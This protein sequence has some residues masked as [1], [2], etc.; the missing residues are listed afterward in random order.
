[1]WSQN[2]ELYRDLILPFSEVNLDKNLKQLNWTSRAMIKKADDFYI[3]L[4]LPKMAKTFWEKSYFKRDK[5]FRNCHGTAAN[6][7]NGS[8]YRFGWHNSLIYLHQIKMLTEIYLEQLK[9]EAFF[10]VFQN[11]HLFNIDVG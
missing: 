3:S 5:D 1:M 11:D 9:F 6:M 7:F 8:D 4:G 10:V 2:W